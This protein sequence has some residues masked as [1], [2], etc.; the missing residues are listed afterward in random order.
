MKNL[1]SLGASWVGMTIGVSLYS[2]A[3]LIPKW[4]ELSLWPI[5]LGRGRLTGRTRLSFDGDRGL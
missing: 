3:A 1:Q 5:D 4:V 2:F